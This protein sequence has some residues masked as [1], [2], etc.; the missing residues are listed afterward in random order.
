MAGQ[1]Y[2]L[3]EVK[4][5]VMAKTMELN[6]IIVNNLFLIIESCFL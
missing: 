4:Q 1:P 5:E 3:R 6:K 2:L